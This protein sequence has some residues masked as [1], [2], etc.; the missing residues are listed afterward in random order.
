[1]GA[2]EDVQSFPTKPEASEDSC[3][4]AKPTGHRRLPGGIDKLFGHSSTQLRSC[5]AMGR[6]L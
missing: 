2:S 1:M 6:S 5:T 4:L 3:D